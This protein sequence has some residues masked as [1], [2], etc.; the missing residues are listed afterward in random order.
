MAGPYTV[1]STQKITDIQSAFDKRVFP[2]VTLWN[3]LEGRPRTDAFDRALRAEVRDA[4]WMLSRQWQMGEFQGDDAGS[5]IFARVHLTTTRLDRYRPGEHPVEPFDDATPLE[6][7][8]E[9]RHIPFTVGGAPAALD[10]R[11]LLGRQWVK[12]LNA[13]LGGDH[14]AD[15]VAAYPVDVPDPTDPAHAPLCAHPEAWSRFAAVGGRRMD[16]WK[17]YAHLAADPSHHAYDGIGAL[18]GR[19]AEVEAVEARW[20]AWYERLFTQPAADGVDAWEPSRLEYRFACSAPDLEGE[21]VLAAEEYYHGRL[22]WYSLD[23]DAEAAALGDPGAGTP[24]APATETQVLLPTP[25]AF[26]GMPHTRWWTFEDRRT[27]FGD[28]KPDTTDIAKLLLMEFGLVYANDW[29]MIPYTLKAGSLVRILGMAV[30][31]VFGERTWVEAAGRGPDDAWQRW[32]MY[33]QST[34][35]DAGHPADTGLCLLPTVP[36]VQEGRPLEEVLLLRDEVANLVWGVEATVPLA[37]GGGKPG[38]EAARETLAWF[39]ADLERRVGAGTTVPAP[40]PATTAAIRYQVMNTVPENW[41]PFI[42]V[43]VP[44]SVRE[45][46]LQRAAL[47][48]ILEGDP[49]DPQRVRPR[50][51]LLR[52]GLDGAQAQPLFLHEEEVPRAGV[53]VTQSFQRT[54]WRDGRVW[55]WLGARKQTGRGEGASGLAFDRVVDVPPSQ[56]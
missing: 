29:F 37:G 27:S 35:G 46:Q 52:Q 34:R 16:G 12:M 47:P 38:A 50:T 44:G 53:R 19:E 42:P 7:E 4:L 48:R 22:D 6:A 5:P 43:H 49:D 2:T 31:N 9:R 36:K 24:A 15:F 32:A 28:I 45:V 11:L 39:R 51:A 20:R 41:I 21:K 33:L 10:L 26:E 54:R 14:T 18:A 30:T 13:A 8:V 40:P 25:L 55:V 1:A 23:V 56:P 17:L 3:R